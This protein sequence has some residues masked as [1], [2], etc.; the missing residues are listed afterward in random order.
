MLSRIRDYNGAPLALFVVDHVMPCVLANPI[1]PLFLV[2]KGAGVR[3]LA[4][5]SAAALLAVEAEAQPLD[6]GRLCR[7]VVP[8]VSA[9]AAA[10]VVSTV[11][12]ARVGSVRSPGVGF[13]RD[14]TVQPINT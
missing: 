3:E 13:H 7:P 11:H 4:V 14:E 2:G 1:L 12:R 6:L 10:V 9:A 5:F 8:V